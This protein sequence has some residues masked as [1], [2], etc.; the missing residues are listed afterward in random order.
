MTSRKISIVGAGSASF[1]LAAL[2]GL[3][4][5]PE[6]EGCRLYLH[7]IDEAAVVRM[8]DLGRHLAATGRLD[9]R[10]ESG[11]DLA[12]CLDGADCVILSVAVDREECWELDREIGLRHGINHYAENGGPAAIFHAARN[13]GL[14]LPV[15][16]EMERR[17]PTAWLL[18]YTNPVPRICTAIQRYSRINSLGVCHQVEFGYYLA[19]VLL[20]GELGLDLPEDYNFK[21]TDGHCRQADEIGAAARARITIHAGGLNHFTWA[22][23]VRDR[24]TGKDLY[25]QLFEGAGKVRDDFEPLSRRV[26]E[27]YGLLPTPGDTHLCEYLA[28]THSPARGTWER[29]DLQ[30]YDFEWSRENRRTH[31]A[32]A[33]R[34]IEGG[35]WELLDRIHTERA[36]LIAAALFSGEHHVDEALNLPN[37]GAIPNLPDSAVVEVPVAFMPDGPRPVT[38]PPLPAAVAELCRRQVTINELSVAGIVEG[39]RAKLIQALALDPMVDDPDLPVKLLDD[40]LRAFE[41]YQGL[42]RFRAR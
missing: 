26:L 2:K 9:K 35:R 25:P 29:Y 14:V 36:E 5:S 34:I 13:I 1:G 4:L 38:C 6:L 30:M 18:N 22:Y 41:K 16:M 27:L 37:R 31:A 17:C 23:A 10:V 21:W 40:Y 7:D 28:Y 8:G 11:T 19:G 39:D 24:V 33:Q 15:L 32:L 12:A 42:A 3:L 20:A